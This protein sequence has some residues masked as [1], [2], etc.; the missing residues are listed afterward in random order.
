MC[1]QATQLPLRVAVA[2]LR[3]G[4]SHAGIADS[5]PRA[6]LAAL[7]DVDGETLSA[8]CQH[9]NVPGFRSIDELA[10]ARVADAVVIA[11]PTRFHAEMAVQAL[12]AGLHVLLEKPLCR[13]DDEAARIL[14]AVNRNQAVLQVGYE[15][16]SSPLFTSIR[17]HIRFGDLGEVTNVWWNQHADQSGYMDSWRSSR[18]NMGG[19]LFDCAVHF[20]DI[21]QQWAG[22]PLVRVAA[23]GNGRRLTGACT[24]GVPDSAVIIL[25]YANGVRG[26]YNLGAVNTFHD[27]AS[28]GVAGTTGRVQ[29]NPIEA[30]SYELRTHRGQRVGHLRFDPILTSAGHL[31]F[32]EQFGNWVS[33]IC[34]GGVNV[35]PI[36]D[37]VAIH[38]MM[39]ALDVSLR[40]GRVVELTEIPTISEC[41]SLSGSPLAAC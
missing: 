11:V 26:T 4:I 25:E 39:R 7:I 23:F 6:N 38:R 21:L 37:A 35:C 34:D 10:S 5:S 8:A 40:E 14:A 33:A 16:R 29:G 20:L 24:D 31:G 15:V 1:L 22:A 32:D 3:H 30:G 12:D 18:E 36:E 2:G 28:F 13:S 19:T 27:D 41:Q 17:D 9:F